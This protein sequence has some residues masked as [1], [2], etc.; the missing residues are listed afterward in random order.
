VSVAETLRRGREKRRLL[1]T[2]TVTVTRV[3]GRVFDPSTGTYTDTT[4]TQY[5]GIAD[6]KNL[7]VGAGQAQAGEREI[8]TRSYDVVLPFG[9]TADIRIDDRVTVNTSDD[10]NLVGLMLTV[11]DPQY[12]GR[13]TGRH[14]M[15]EI[16]A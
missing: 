2:D 16:R 13:R 6:V 7:Q 3:T 4:V 1:M 15:A 9:T 10:P 11:T 12:G 8:T 14:V 5:T